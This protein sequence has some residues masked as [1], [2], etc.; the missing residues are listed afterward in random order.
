[1]G[2]LQ[3]AWGGTAT[4]DPAPAR[5]EVLLLDVT[6]NG[7]RL[8]GVVRVEQRASDG[9]L[10][11]AD[12]WAEARLAPLAQTRI[13]SDG[14]PAYALDAVPGATYRINRQTL[15]LEVHA[16]ADAFAGSSLGLQGTPA[17]AAPPHRQP[18][19]MLNYDLSATYA[20]D[21]RSTTSGAVLEAI[22]F[23]QFGNLVVSA[24]MRNDA[25][26]SG[27][28]RLDSFW[29]Y[30]MPQRMETL[31][32]GDTVGVGGGWSQPVRYAG[33][34]WGRDFGMRPGFVTVPLPTLSGQATLPSTVEVLVNNARRMSRPMPP[35]PFALTEVPIGTGA[36]ELNLVVR[37]LLGRET[38]VRQSY[39]ASPR[40]LSPGLTDYSLEAGWLRTGYGQ[41]SH[42]GDGFAAG[43]SRTGLTPSV[44]G[45]VRLE[46]Q[47][48]RRAAGVELAGLLGGWAVGRMALA[49]SAGSTQGLSEHGQLLRLGVE[50]STTRGGAALQYEQASR[51]F[52]PFGE[53]TGAA[54]A[55][56]RARE[57]WTASIGGTLW[58]PASGG[59][60]Y[61]HQTGWDG[62]RVHAMGVSA[63][64]P[65]W[66]GAS[67]SLSLNKRLDGD[68]AWRAGLSVSLPLDRG[69]HTAARVDR[70][71]DGLL[72]GAM[73]ASVS[74]PA[75]PG[76]GWRVDAST[77]EAQRARGGLQ[78]N[79]SQAEWTLDV[80][81]DSRGRVAARADGRGTVGLLG[82]MLFVSRPVGQGGFAVVEVPGLAGVPVK[83]SHQVVAETDARGLAF[84]PGLLPW[85]TNR[86]EIDPVDLP[87][88]TEVGDVVQEVRPYAGSG[89]LL[90]FDVRRTRRALLVLH[91][92]DGQPVPVG[93]RV[94]LLP[95]GPEFL[96]GRRGEAWLTDLAVAH[97]VL[98]V[99]WTSGG[100]RLDLT[101]PDSGRSDK[102]GPLLCGKES[103]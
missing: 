79:T 19:I 91:Q 23:N 94:R 13:L 55:A 86:I 18:G 26:S 88:D 58:G 59:L 82:G 44:T 48:T 50:R 27:M 35:G 98:Q 38:V 53:G 49:T 17:A 61:V 31:V 67:M 1:M 25:A 54:M 81:S 66:R 71:G 11:P 73:S 32:V 30:D 46:L 2:A 22:A 87:L 20:A 64:L 83:R 84:V 3:L 37:D 42:Y 101:V 102:V 89:S 69:I 34:R 6:V 29:R 43:T 56:Q 45:E 96:V 21:G 77:Q 72:T 52:A 10:L 40:L 80:A 93:A 36:G 75:G 12:A 65:L 60:S 5:T 99:S 63:S 97:Q 9:L 15:S 78:Y 7:M 62:E 51:G 8:A 16:P 100:C 47:A 74:A 90:K 103:P 28:Q 41:D 92:Q 4:T 76:L 39:Y 68:R 95:G 14:T 85:Q 70:S 57:R 24:L 33:V